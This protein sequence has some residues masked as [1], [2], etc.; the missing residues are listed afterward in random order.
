MCFSATASFAAG[1]ALSAAGLVTLRKATKRE[2]M[3]ASIPLLFGL[4]QL[5]DGVVWVTPETSAVHTVAVYGYSFLAFAFWPVFVVL[6]VRMVEDDATRKKILDAL[7]IIGAGVSAFFLHAIL[8]NGT[9]ARLLHHC[10]AYYTPHAYNMSSVAFYL[11][12]VCGAFFVSSNKI[13]RL[14]GVVLLLSFAIAGWFYS[15]TFSST[16]C[17]FSA[18]LSIILMFYFYRR[19]EVK[20]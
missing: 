6:A 9:T 18:V 13:L 16:W 4:Q 5:I 14:F 10:V 20:R 7:L 1:G 2:L 19:P 17:F 3:L 12:A 8:F 11:V 15:A